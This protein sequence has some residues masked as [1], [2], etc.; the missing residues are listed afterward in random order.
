MNNTVE[1]TRDERAR[2]E[3]LQLAVRRN[4]DGQLKADVVVADA[5]AFL[6]FLTS[7]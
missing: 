3:A 2:V 7:K 4:H 5:K 1:S 6:D